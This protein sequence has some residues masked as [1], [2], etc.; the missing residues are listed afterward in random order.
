MS[1]EIEAIYENGV[2][3]LDQLLPL[4]NGQ[5]VKV[6][7]HQ[8]SGR[9]RASAGIFPWKGNRQ[10]LEYLLGPSNQPWNTEE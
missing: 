1:L 3:K 5:R 4:K 6:T 8:P 7:V 10:D 9:A 2:L